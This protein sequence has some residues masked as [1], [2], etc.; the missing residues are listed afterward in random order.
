[1]D[2]CTSYRYF[3]KLRLPINQDFGLFHIFNEERIGQWTAGHKV[4]IPIEQGG[5]LLTQEK[6]IVSIVF[7]ADAWLKIYQQVDVA[8]VGEPGGGHRA[9]R[10]KAF[11]P[12]LLAESLYCLKLILDDGMQ[13]F[14]ILCK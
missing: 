11:Y 7:D 3:F 13:T 4:N 1:M 9:E 12:T 5:K 6:E 8:P 10:I 14:P 2:C